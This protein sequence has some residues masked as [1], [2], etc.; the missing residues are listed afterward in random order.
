MFVQNYLISDVN[1][2]PSRASHYCVWGNYTKEWLKEKGADPGAIHVTG[3]LRLSNAAGR[4]R[5]ERTD[6]LQL[7]RVP[8]ETSIIALAT[9]PYT[10]QTN[11]AIIEWFVDTL[12]D[13]PYVLVIKP[14][15]DD[16]IDYRPWIGEKIR[17]MPDA[18]TLQ[19]LLNA[20][21]IAATIASTSGVEAALFGK[22]LIVLMP[23]I[24]YHFNLHHNEYPYHLA[25]AKAGPIVRSA[26]ELREA[27]LA[28]RVQEQNREEV[29]RLGQ[30]FLKQTLEIDRVGPAKKIGQLI[31]HI[32]K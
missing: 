14:H 2:I 12:K 16:M 18:Y 28:L 20:C 29:V 22:P 17:M 19:D 10:E 3:S 7:L 32:M 24:P 26:W 4:A 27:L 9:S 1:V 15:P 5:K 8:E 23:V 30:T 6:L 13:L 11:H 31:E 25:K 21:D